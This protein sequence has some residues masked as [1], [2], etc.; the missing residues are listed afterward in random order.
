MVAELIPTPPAVPD[1]LFEDV[2]SIPCP[3]A[4]PPPE[5]PYGAPNPLA[6]FPPRFTYSVPPVLA[7]PASTVPP[8]GPLPPPP[9]PPVVEPYAPAANKKP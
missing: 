3:P 6:L 7:F 1:A 8:V 5:P 9:A 2:K 4:P